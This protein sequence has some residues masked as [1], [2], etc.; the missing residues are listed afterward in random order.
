MSQNRIHLIATEDKLIRIQEGE[1]ESGFWDLTEKLADQLVGGLI[2][3]HNERNQ[4]SYFGGRIQSYRV[5]DGGDRDGRI[6]FRFRYE[7]ECRGIR[8]Q[9]KWTSRDRKLVMKGY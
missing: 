5:Q 6:V 7:E 8:T 1:Y 4:P 2:V 9:G 3:F